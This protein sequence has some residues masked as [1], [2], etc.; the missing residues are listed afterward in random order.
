MLGVISGC[1]SN[2]TDEN[3]TTNDLVNQLSSESIEDTADG[4]ADGSTSST[5][6]SAL[7]QLKMESSSPAF[8]ISRSCAVD[9]GTGVTT[10]TASY[11]GTRSLSFDNGRIA[12]SCSMTQAGTL[13][14]TW[15]PK[16]AGD[17]SCN[18]AMTYAKVP[19]GDNTKIDGLQ[20]IQTF[21]R[22]RNFARTFSRNGQTIKSR[23]DNF[24]AKGTR[25]LTWGTGTVAD[26]L[27]T[28]VNTLTSDVIRNK[29]F[30][31]GN[32]GEA[33][34]TMTVKTMND[35]PIQVEVV[36]T[37]ISPWD[38]Q[39]KTV[40]S[41]TIQATRDGG[42][43]AEVTFNDVVFDLRDTNVNKCLPTSG[44]ITGKYFES[45]DATTPSH[46]FTITFGASTSSGVSISRD[47]ADA[48]DYDTYTPKGCDLEWDG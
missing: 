36:R 39:T 45:A 38:I 12:M 10:V 15:T 4:I 34:I 28:R 20:M 41:G 7:A 48:E 6:L 3:L 30:T 42:G 46:T 13:T 11:T 31:K 32:G 18:T 37:S 33:S 9:D 21:D 16:T 26:G 43:R 14:R 40:K 8:N 25:T 24:T 17:I 23:T 29:T 2:N 35:A 44:S 19:W 27:L 47:G 5:A 22:T 1:S